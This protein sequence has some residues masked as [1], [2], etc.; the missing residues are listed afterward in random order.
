MTLTTLVIGL[1]AASRE[2][3]IA[4]AVNP[5]IPTALILE[6]NATGVCQLEPLAAL[7]MIQIMRIA[8]GC[9][10]CVG[11]LTLRVTLNRILRHPPKRLFISLAASTHIAQLQMLLTRAPYDTMLTLTDVIDCPI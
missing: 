1:R 8:P 7:D 3:A 6:G 2:A 9:M 10:C 4:A 11:N 5:V